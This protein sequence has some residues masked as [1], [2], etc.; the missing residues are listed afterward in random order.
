MNQNTIEKRNRFTFAYLELMRDPIF[1]KL[2]FNERSRLIKETL[3]SAREMALWAEAEFKADDPRVLA[4]LLGIKVYGREKGWQAGKPKKSEYLSD[5]NEIII[6]RDVLERLL[7]QI[8]EKSLSE[9]LL[10]FLVAHQL[11]FHLE[12]TR[13]GELPKKFRIPWIKVGNFVVY[14][15]VKRLSHLAAYAFACHLLKVNFSPKVFNFLV[16]IFYLNSI[17]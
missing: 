11:Y 15:D 9:C 8:D 12:K 5:K 13:F 16:D 4:T 6:Y 10:R 14:R 1:L 3:S 7:P 2:P 17:N